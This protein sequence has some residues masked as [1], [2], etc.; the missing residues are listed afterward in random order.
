M[1]HP[2][3]ALLPAVLLGTGLAYGGAALTA[4]AETPVRGGVLDFVVGSTI[5]S[6]DAHQETTFGVVHPIG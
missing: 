2:N 1:R 3:I 5:P 4:N 6:Y